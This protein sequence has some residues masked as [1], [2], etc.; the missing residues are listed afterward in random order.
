MGRSNTSAGSPIGFGSF[1]NQSAKY[2]DLA[3]YEALNN[4]RARN[5]TV[6]LFHGGVNNQNTSIG[7]I[8]EANLNVQMIVA[9]I[10]SL[11]IAHTPCKFPP[12]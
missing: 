2:S 10:D 6:E 3:K 1:L 4:L 5:F 12:R 9:L 7:D 11:P 8:E